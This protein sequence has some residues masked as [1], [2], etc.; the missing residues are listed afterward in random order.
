MAQY[1]TYLTVYSGNKLPPF[2]IGSTSVERINKGYRGSVLSKK[3]REIWKSELKENPHLFETKILTSH[4]TREE[5]LDQEMCLQELHDVVRSPLY[6]NMAIAN[7]KL[8]FCEH[9]DPEFRKKQ[10]AAAKKRWESEEARKKI[11]KAHIGKILSTEHKQKI[12]SNKKGK[13]R[14]EEQK[15]KMSESQKKRFES[16]EERKKNSIAAKIG[17]AS[18]EYRKK[19]RETINNK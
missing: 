18:E 17:W 9:N 12:S 11:S 13:R 8:M 1:C 14:T 2:Y 16:E 7:K 6:I 10:S 4:S 5:A 15:R 19:R 3:Y